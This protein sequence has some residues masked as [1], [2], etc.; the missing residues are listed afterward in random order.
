ME[1]IEDG[2]EAAEREL[3]GLE[4]LRQAGANRVAALAGQAGA[5]AAGHRPGRM[6]LLAAQELD[7]LLAELPQANAPGAKSGSAAIRP[8]MFRPAG[9]LSMPR[10]RSGPLRWK[11]DSAC[12]WTIWPRFM[13]R[14]SLVA[15]G[16]MVTARILSPA[17]AEAS[18]WLTGQMPQIRAVIPGISQRGRPSQNFS[19]PRNS[20][21]W[22]RASLDLAS[23]IELDRDL[24]VTFDPR[25]GVDQD[26]LC[27]RSDLLPSLSRT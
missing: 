8:K 5:N 15:A 11:N 23:V 22:K 25:H 16:G 21:T 19:N 4:R 6:D 12:D 13:S 10:S 3:G 20:A 27:H 24:G 18:K 1:L 14:R 26:L 7:D 9:S 2:L 17:L